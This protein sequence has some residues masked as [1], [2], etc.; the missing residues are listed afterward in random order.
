MLIGT[1]GMLYL[2][3]QMDPKPGT[4]QS[5]GM[6][7]AF[8]LLLFFTNLSGLL[9]LAFRESSFMGTLLILHLGLVLAFFITMP[10]GKFVHGVYRYIAL[11]RHS[12]EQA[13]SAEE[14]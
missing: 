4:P 7:V 2:K 12:Q 9:L 13:K 3:T 1:A 6:D 10:F 11:V 5:L 8:G 14:L